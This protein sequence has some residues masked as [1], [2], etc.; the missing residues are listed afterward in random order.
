MNQI[1]Y[2][3]H[4]LYL[5]LHSR[6]AEYCAVSLLGI[7]AFSRPSLPCQKQMQKMLSK[8]NL[9]KLESKSNKIVILNAK[10]LLLETNNFKLYLKVVVFIRYIMWP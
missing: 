10:Y 7:L 4:P 1:R 5:P 9:Y 3:S 8:V 6:P 2:E